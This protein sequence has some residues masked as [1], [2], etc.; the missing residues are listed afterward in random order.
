M[1]VFYQKLK[2]RKT[3]KKKLFK[4]LCF[5]TIIVFYFVLFLLETDGKW[6]IKIFAVLE[7]QFYRKWLFQTSRSKTVREDAFLVAKSVIFQEKG[8]THQNTTILTMCKIYN[9]N[10]TKTADI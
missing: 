7:I 5:H 2:F 3:F 6:K 10:K 4:I 9:V 8:K 1:P